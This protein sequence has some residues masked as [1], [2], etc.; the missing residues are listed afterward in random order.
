MLIKVEE[1]AEETFL[2]FVVS[3]MR[4]VLVFVAFLVLVFVTVF[5]VRLWGLCGSRRR[6]WGG[7]RFVSSGTLNDLIQLA[8][9]EPHPAAGR[10]II[11]FY[12]L[13]V[14]HHQC[15]VAV[16]AFHVV[17]FTTRPAICIPVIDGPVWHSF[18]SH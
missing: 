7:L 15:F 1:I 10:T 4:I 2:L 17:K 6:G 9:I 3:V 11:N 18:L 12:T 5:V 16:W 14:S 13:A 8:T